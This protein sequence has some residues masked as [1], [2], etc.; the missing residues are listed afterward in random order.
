[1]LEAVVMFSMIVILVFLTIAVNIFLKD[2]ARKHQWTKPEYGAAAFGIN[3]SVALV[4]E[5]L[6][7]VSLLAEGLAEVL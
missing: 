3:M 4:D 2:Y 7:V 1:M 5:L 6:V